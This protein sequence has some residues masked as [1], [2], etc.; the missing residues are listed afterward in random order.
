MRYSYRM[1]DSTAAQPLARVL[2]TAVATATAGRDGAVKTSDGKLEVRV[3]PPKELGG[4]G[5]GTNP[6]QLFAA[7]YAA[8]FGSACQHVARAREY[9]ARHG[10]YQEFSYEDFC[11]APVE[12]MR[13]V[14][15]RLGVPWT[16]EVERFL[17]ERIYTHRIGVAAAAPDG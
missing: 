13:P 2:Y 7:G 12:V 15:D 4:A 17:A 16:P 3:S 6:E 11:R 9:G 14:F 10:A 8:C 5:D 1:S